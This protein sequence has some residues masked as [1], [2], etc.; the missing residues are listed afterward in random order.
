MDDVIKRAVEAAAEAQW[1]FEGGIGR[2]GKP[3]TVTWIDGVAEPDKQR[4]RDRVL[5][6]IRGALPVIG[7]ELLSIVE[8]HG[9]GAGWLKDSSQKA[10]DK[11]GALVHGEAMASA[12]IIGATIRARLKEMKG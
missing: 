5:P 9:E 8:A 12:A 10:G 3:R 1:Q 7:A 4:Y 6:A 2:D 11:I